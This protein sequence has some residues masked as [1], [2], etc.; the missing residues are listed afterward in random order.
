[1]FTPILRMHGYRD[2]VIDPDVPYRDGIAQCNTGSGNELWSFGPTVYEVLLK[3][4]R[5][6]E[7]LRPYV[8]ELMRHAHEHGTPLVRPMFYEF[9]DD[10]RSWNAEDQYMFGSDILVAPVLAEGLR[11]RSVYLP[12]GVP[13]IDPYSGEELA[14]G[15]DVIRETD[16]ATIPVF[17]RKD[18]AAARML[19]PM[20]KT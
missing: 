20:R 15:R 4:L 14:S 19:E 18:S 2:P 6:R 13:W 7:N 3:Y 17:V 11:E 10:A 9:P 8:R 12:A 16:L 1:V 5:L